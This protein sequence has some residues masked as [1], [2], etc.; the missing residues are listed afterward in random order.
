MILYIGEGSLKYL[1]LTRPERN[2]FYFLLRLWVFNCL[3]M[4][5][6]ISF[7]VAFLPSF[8]FQ[9]SGTAYLPL[10]LYS[11]ISINAFATALLYTNSPCSFLSPFNFSSFSSI[12]TWN[13]Q[14]YQYND[15]TLF[16][17]A[18]QTSHHFKENTLIFKCGVL[19]QE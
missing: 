12:D 7:K 3:I 1:Q 14:K 15:S 11:S 4:Y 5:W 16:S 6:I 10:E 17:V 9:I 19:S 8:Q 18:F 2:N 13:Y